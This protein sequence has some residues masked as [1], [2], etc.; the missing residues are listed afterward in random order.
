MPENSNDQSTARDRCVES[1]VAIDKDGA[2][3]DVRL[4]VGGKVLHLWGRGGRDRELEFAASVPAGALPVLLGPNL[5][6]ALNELA[7]AGRPVAV[8]DCEDAVCGVTLARQQYAGT[9]GVLWLADGDV[10]SLRA[11]L[12]EW[13]TAQGGGPFVVL[14]APGAR[15]LPSGGYAELSQALSASDAFWQ[16]ARYPKFQNVQPR[17]LLLDRPYFLQREIKDALTRLDIPWTA[18]DV[19]VGDRMRDGF[20]RELLDRVLEFRPDFVLTVNHLGMDREG[21]LA[22][23]LDRLGLPLAS[24]F[25]DNPHLILAGFPGQSRNGTAVF[26]WDADNVASLTKRGFG[27]VSYL[28]LATDPERFRP[29]LPPGPEEW[30]ANVSFVGDSMTRA[31]AESLHFCRDWDWLTTTYQTLATGFERDGS[32]SVEGY[33][34]AAHPDV[35]R[36]F[37]SLAA[38]EDRL[39]CES[40][41]TWEATRQYRWRCVTALAS[42]APLIAGDAE[43]W[44]QA[45]R[46]CRGD[47][48][49]A[50]FLQ[51]LDYYDDLPRFYPLSAVNLNCTSRQMKGAVNQRVFD[52]PACGGC[53]LTDGQRQLGELF[54]PG[55]EVLVYTDAEEIPELVARLLADAELRQRISTAARARILAQHTYAHRVRVL[56]QH[57]RASFA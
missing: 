7:R 27:N 15:R 57:M 45:F 36:R 32:G 18:V 23:L 16:S 55:K 50:R 2:I 33:L 4:T 25:V 10:E 20:V 5:G 8:V 35:A 42:F 53:L 51:R 54:E 13:Q 29:G 40:L 46:Q 12:L 56:C 38:P 6:V 34:K 11:R 19:G 52:V 1:A 31:V 14:L 48:S 3:V 26:T 22:E 9:P 37:A 44:K 21:R 49:T 39:A 43:G 17:V 47:S 28:P 30:R 41:I 24:W